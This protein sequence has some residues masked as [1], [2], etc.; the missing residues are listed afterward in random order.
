MDENTL[1]VLSSFVFLEECLHNRESFSTG[2]VT[3]LG[4][5]DFNVVIKCIAEAICT[6]NSSTG[7]SGTGEFQ[8]L[9]TFGEFLVEF[10]SSSLAFKEHIGTN[11][12]NIE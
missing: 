8:N 10:F 11:V 5:D 1:E 3:G 6:T 4:I 2:E 9:G 12:S 7:T